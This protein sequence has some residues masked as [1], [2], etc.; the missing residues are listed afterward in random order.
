L[1]I[2]KNDKKNTSGKISFSL[3]STIGKCDFDVFCTEAEI[4]ESL[5]FYTTY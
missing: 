2:M 4:F 3:L 1:E 5:D